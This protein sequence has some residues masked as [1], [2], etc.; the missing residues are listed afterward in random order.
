M[1]SRKSNNRR[2]SNHRWM[3]MK[4]MSTPT[5]MINSRR[6]RDQK[7]ALKAEFQAA[8]LAKRAK[9]AKKLKC[10]MTWR[11]MMTLMKMR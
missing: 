11:M 7:L 5:V 6:A 8:A 2:K 10:L 9:M 4:T 1:S 3:M